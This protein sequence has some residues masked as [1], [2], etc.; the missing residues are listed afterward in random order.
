MQ[1]H[2]QSRIIHDFE[3]PLSI[4]ENRRLRLPQ[5]SSEE[6]LV[7]GILIEIN[8]D[9]VKIDEDIVLDLRKWIDSDEDL[10]RGKRKKRS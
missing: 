3:N 8:K 7:D 9:R 5:S 2:E 10:S 1:L 4:K 6:V